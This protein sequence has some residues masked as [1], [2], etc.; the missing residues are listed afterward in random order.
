MKLMFLNRF[1]AFKS[2]AHLCDGFDL[3]CLIT[4]LVRLKFR[5]ATKRPEL[6]SCIIVPSKGCRRILIKKNSNW[7]INSWPWWK[8]SQRLTKEV[9]DNS[10]GTWITWCWETMI[11]VVKHG[12]SH[13]KHWFTN[14]ARIKRES[15]NDRHTENDYSDCSHS[16]FLFLFKTWSFLKVFIMMTEV[17]LIKSNIKGSLYS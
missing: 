8:M 10:Y 15:R 9:K 11:Q 1:V 17:K 16:D 5:G 6:I 3:F 13:Q 12:Q 2:C 14:D 7:I 4:A